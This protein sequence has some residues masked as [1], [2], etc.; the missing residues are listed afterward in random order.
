MRHYLDQGEFIS[1]KL[2]GMEYFKKSLQMGNPSK[3]AE[4]SGRM[5]D[6][7]SQVFSSDKIDNAKKLE[8]LEFVSSEMTKS[9]EVSPLDFRNYLYL[10]SFLSRG[11]SLLDSNNTDLLQQAD[12]VLSEAQ[13]LAPDKQLLYLE[14]GKVKS[15][16]GDYNAAAENFKKAADLNPA[17]PGPGWELAIAFVQSG[18]IEQGSLEA[19]RVREI[20]LS[21]D[22]N[23]KIDASNELRLA[24]AYSNAGDQMLA[25]EIYG[26]IMEYRQDILDTRTFMILA[27]QFAK[28][29]DKDNAILAAQRVAEIDP[30]LK[31]QSEGFIQ[32]VQSR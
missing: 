4:I 10:A 22:P 28:Q 9:I 7:A 23:M 31:E 29:G 14:W 18:Q 13:P 11:H 17:V 26:K 6:Y 5:A 19:N 8:W 12:K 32:A 30:S 2:T 3:N 16:L 21:G 25:S 24:L 15:K 27:E 1:V 20:I